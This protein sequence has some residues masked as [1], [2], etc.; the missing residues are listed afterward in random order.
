MIIVTKINKSVM[1]SVKFMFI[2]YSIFKNKIKYCT[3]TTACCCFKALLQDNAVFTEQMQLPRAFPSEKVKTTTFPNRTG[4]NFWTEGVVSTFRVWIQTAQINSKPERIIMGPLAWCFVLVP[5]SIA[6][7]NKNNELTS[8]QHLICFSLTD[9]L[10]EHLCS[11]EH[12][13]KRKK[14]D[15]HFGQL[16][17]Q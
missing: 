7:P 17:E 14:C 9:G 15:T 4:L 8:V 16:V 1:L 3:V 6:T 12:K 11:K 2:I 13:G 10:W 5:L